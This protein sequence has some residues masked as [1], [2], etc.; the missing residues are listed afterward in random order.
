MDWQSTLRGDVNEQWD[1]FLG[2]LKGLESQFV[3]QRKLHKR[4]HKAPWITYK[5]IKLVNRKHNLYRKYKSVRHPAY[6]KAAREANREVRH[7][8]RS[9][10]R[11]LAENIDK[12]RKLFYDCAESF[13]NQGNNRA[14]SG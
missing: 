14:I 12:D 9:F 1:I 10:E 13:K 4:R 8:K 5:A 6:A 2:I 3:P 11:K 7:A